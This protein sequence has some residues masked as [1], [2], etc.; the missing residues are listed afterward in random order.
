MEVALCRCDSEFVGL[1]QRTHGFVV[2]NNWTTG[3]IAGVGHLETRCSRVTER[4]VLLRWLWTCG[5]YL[6]PNPI[7]G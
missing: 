6:A 7:D 2:D 3:I 5:E 1:K 4:A